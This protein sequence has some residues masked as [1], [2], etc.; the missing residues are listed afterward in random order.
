MLTKCR[1]YYG[2][3]LAF[4]P[5][6]MNSAMYPT[7]MKKWFFVG[8][9]FFRSARAPT[10]RKPAIV[11]ASSIG[12]AIQPCYVADVLRR[13]ARLCS[14]LWIMGKLSPVFSS[15]CHSNNHLEGKAK[16][17][18]RWRTYRTWEKIVL[19]ERGYSWIMWIYSLVKIS[20][21]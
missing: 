6:F 20:A 11:F 13:M 5:W 10:P 9:R 1:F 14:L 19:K 12:A 4:A 7:K 18:Q 15:Y 16:R 17:E 2:V 8:K 3:N 21:R